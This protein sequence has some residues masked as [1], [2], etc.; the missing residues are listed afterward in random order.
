ML[1][2][3]IGFLIWKSIISGIIGTSVMEMLFRMCI[4]SGVGNVDMVRAIG[5]LITKS[6][7]S[8][9]KVGVIVHYIS[10]IFFAFVYAIIFILFDVTVVLKYAGAG[11]IIGFI[12]GTIVSFLLIIAVAEHHPLKEFQTVGFSVA[13]AHWAG[14]LLFGLSVGLV[15]GLMG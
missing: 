1:D 11:I 13:L 6:M 15:F 7:D 4:K 5:S 8:A 9:Y 2:T 3:S 12:H 14:H 10:G